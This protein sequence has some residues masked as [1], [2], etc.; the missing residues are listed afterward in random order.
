VLQSLPEVEV[1]DVPSDPAGYVRALQRGLWFESVGITDADRM[2]KEQYREEQQRRDSEQGA[3][4]VEAYLESLQMR[5]DVRELDEQDME[6]AVQLLGKTNQFNVTTRR[7]TT[8]IVRGMLAEPR[9]IALTLRLADRF[10][11][12]G[13]VSL[14]MAV[15]EAGPAAGAESST[16]RIDTWLMS[17]RVIARTVEDL[18]LNHLA[19]RAVE[20][21]YRRV[22]GEF[23]PTAKNQLVADLYDRF[24]FTRGPERG[25]GG[26]DYTLDLSSFTARPTPIKPVN[27]S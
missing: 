20:L 5:A 7:H 10:G 6:R 3:V 13:L 12:A 26:R 1:V 18:L 8:E 19:H 16:L 9:S 24:G 4:S 22:H 15:P 23:I 27:R 14:V 17:C 11:D 21:G 25:D 2:R